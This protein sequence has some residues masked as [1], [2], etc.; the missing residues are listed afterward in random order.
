MTR[1][2]APHAAPRARLSASQAPPG[3]RT[4]PGPSEALTEQ[5][6]LPLGNADQDTKAATLSQRLTDLEHRH[7]ALLIEQGRREQAARE[8][9]ERNCRYHALGL[10]RDALHDTLADARNLARHIAALPDH[11]SPADLERLRTLA[12]DALDHPERADARAVREVIDRAQQAVDDAKAETARWYNRAEHAAR[13][14]LNSPH[15]WSAL[16][17]AGWEAPEYVRM[18]ELDAGDKC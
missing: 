7:T 4:S 17:G 10:M 13:D 16:I 15:V 14:A 6:S 18:R 11:P 8:A 9:A 1:S 12:R 5:L 2:R 3:P